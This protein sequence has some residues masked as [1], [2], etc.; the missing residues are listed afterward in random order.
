MNEYPVPPNPTD[1]RLWAIVSQ[2]NGLL[3]SSLYYDMIG[4][5]RG[6]CMVYRVIRTENGSS[7]TFDFD[8]IEDAHAW[9]RQE[10]EYD[11]HCIDPKIGIY[12]I[13]EIE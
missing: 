6:V 10:K 2:N 4:A 5:E 1:L 3:T 11:E 13:L 8:D 12:E 9:V 7:T